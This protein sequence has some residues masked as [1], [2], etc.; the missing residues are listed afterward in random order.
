MPKTY[1]PLIIIGAPRSGTNILRDV[2]CAQPGFATWPCDEINYTWRYR[3][4]HFPDDELT[5][6]LITPAVGRYIEKQFAWVA[7]KYDSPYVVEK[8]CA[9]C[10]RVDFVHALFPRAFYIYIERDGRDAAASAKLRWQAGLD[11]P[12]LLRKARFVPARDLPFYAGRYLW[13]HIYRLFSSREKGLAIWGPRFAG[14]REAVKQFSLIE[15][16]GLQ[17]LTCVRKS[18]E[19]LTRLVEPGR[20]C[21]I[22]YE[23]FVKAPYEELSRVFDF[24]RLP[25][26]EPGLVKACGHVKPGSV[27]KWRETLSPTEQVLLETLLEEEPGAGGFLD[28]GRRLT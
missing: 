14:Y 17:W 24:F 6:D 22:R 18:Q 2:I 20:R 23:D 12:Y 4:S 13:T 25:T 7:R 19:A 5:P 27:G 3:N 26:D 1:Q 10:L 8:T 28:R 9:N 11:I 16:C 21:D 15:V